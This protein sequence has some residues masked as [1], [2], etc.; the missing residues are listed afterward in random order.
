MPQVDWQK[1]ALNTVVVTLT[2]TVNFEKMRPCGL[3]H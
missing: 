3:D 1:V 2:K